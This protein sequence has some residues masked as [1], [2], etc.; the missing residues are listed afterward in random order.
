MYS[1]GLILMTPQLFMNYKN[2]SVAFLPWKRF[3]YPGCSL[4][5]DAFAEQANIR[6]RVRQKVTIEWIGKASPT[7]SKTSLTS[8]LPE[9]D[10]SN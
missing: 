6:K 9:V 10:I 7:I 2:K 4:L 3:V 5:V 1:L 8:Q